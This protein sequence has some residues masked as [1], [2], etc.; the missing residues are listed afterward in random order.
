[1]LRVEVVM[2]Q[3]VNPRS[4]ADEVE[5]QLSAAILGGALAAGQTLPAERELAET[6][7]VNRGAVREAIQ[8]LAAAGLVQSRQGQGT[9]VLDFQREGGLDLLPGLLIQAERVHGPA[10][11]GL[12]ELRTCIGVDAAR[13]AA[14]RQG[15][16]EPLRAAMRT[17]EQAPAGTRAAPALALWEAVID[18]ADNLAYRLAFNSLRRCYEPI[19]GLVAPVLAAE[20]EDLDAHLHLGEAILA[21]RDEE[22]ADRAALLLQR[23]EQALVALARGLEAQP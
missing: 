3:S 18:R 14:R 19:L 15:E 1:M 20:V 11:R 7:G 17:L 8:R 12:A 4:R 9:R 23:G 10:L 16:E 6:L 21:G 2:F 5:R 13:R 22:A